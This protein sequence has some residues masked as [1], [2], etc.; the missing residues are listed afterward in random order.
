MSRQPHWLSGALLISIALMAAGPSAQAQV[1]SSSG[2]CPGVM[3]F[4][5]TGATPNGSVAFVHSASTGTW[6]IPF[7]VVCWGTTTGLSAPVVLAGVVPTNTA[8][9]TSV[10]AAVPAAFC[11][12]RFLQAIDLTNCNTTNVILIQ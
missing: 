10:N 11:G 3:N 5:V 9:N 4:Q 6:T 1:L 7:G 8:G 2:V 12:S